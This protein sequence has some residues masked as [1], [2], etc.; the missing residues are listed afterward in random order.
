MGGTDQNR[1]VVCCLCHDPVEAS[2]WCG[3]CQRWPINITPIRFCL[4]AHRVD[5]DGFC[6]VCVDYVRTQL[7]PGNGE[8]RDT[9]QVAVLNTKRENQR[10]ARD[11]A[12]QLSGPGWPETLVPLNARCIPRRWKRLKLV[13][14]GRTPKGDEV[15]IP[16]TAIPAGGIWENGRWLDGQEHCDGTPF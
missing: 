5:P 4:K 16:E 3:N 7:F 9:N 6:R 13:V 8:W 15:V 11:L 10:L 12:D 2:G 14:V 1:P